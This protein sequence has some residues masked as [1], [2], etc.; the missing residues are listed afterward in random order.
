MGT[1]ITLDIGGIN[2]TCSK[3]CR[4]FDHGS[5]YQEDNRKRSCAE[6]V[7]YCADT[8]KDKDLA[9]TVKSFVRPLREVIL[10]LELLGFTIDT[11]EHEYTNLVDCFVKENNTMEGDWKQKTNFLAFEEFKAFATQY[12]IKDLC[13]EFI[14]L[15]GQDGE[16]KTRG[17]FDDNINIH[18]TMPLLNHLEIYLD[19]AY[20]EASYFGC[21]M[22]LLHPYNVLSI[23]AANNDNLDID[24]IWRYGDLVDSGYAK[25]EEFISG[26]KRFE[27]FCIVTE[28]VSDSKILK[29]ALAILTPQVEDFFTFI[30][31]EQSYP[32][33]GAGSL[34]NFAKGLV[35]IDVH[36]KML[37]LFDNDAI[38][39]DGH[40][41]LE[42]MTLPS[43][44]CSVILPQLDQFYNFPTQVA[45]TILNAN[46]NFKA[47]AIEC[48]LDLNLK[49]DTEPYVIWTDCDN[50]ICKQHGALHNKA[51]YMKHFLKQN[52]SSV[53]N[54]D[55]KKIKMVL[56]TLISKCRTINW[57]LKNP[58]SSTIP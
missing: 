33:S 56:D 36:N 35:A 16:K 21:V 2:L 17:R 44:I 25:Q 31:R 51:Q 40:T 10:R 4:G 58:A 32:F 29:H 30:N 57:S 38:G 41:K 54:Y 42:N 13:N 53:S 20:S 15:L 12:P 50:N 47:A 52:I 19:H 26:A 23:L 1:Y 37:F 46:I 14:T 6:S 48:Y 11:A 45:Q 8:E 49:N 18:R 43:N 39:Y 34:T 22:S 28:G 27:K 9:E 24:V 55:T 3:N 7:Y 5:L